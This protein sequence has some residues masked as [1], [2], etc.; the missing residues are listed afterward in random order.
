MSPIPCS[1]CLPGRV[2]ASSYTDRIREESVGRSDQRDAVGTE[3]VRQLVRRRNDDRL[4]AR[5]QAA[6]HRRAS[7]SAP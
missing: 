2:S 7:I 5:H 4:C 3:Q 1:H 6:L